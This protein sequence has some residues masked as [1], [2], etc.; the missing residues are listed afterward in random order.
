[1]KKSKKIQSRL[2]SKLTLSLETADVTDQ[3][4]KSKVLLM[5]RASFK[6]HFDQHDHSA[7]WLIVMHDSLACVSQARRDVNQMQSI[8][9]FSSLSLLNNAVHL[10]S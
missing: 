5:S 10:A 7:S 2:A 3:E 9:P 6:P 8:F 1:M 4:L